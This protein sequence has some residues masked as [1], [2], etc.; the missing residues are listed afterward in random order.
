M[1]HETIHGRLLYTSKKPEIL[2]KVRGGETFT[3]TRHLDG[4]RTL[5]AQCAI[6]ENSPRVLRDSITNLDAAWRPKEAFVQITVDEEF[7][8]SSWYRFTDTTAECEGFTAREGR[9]SQKIE[10]DQPAPFFGTH[11]IQAD[12]WHTHCYDMSKGPGEQTVSGYLMCS[13]HHRG[14]DGPLLFKQDEIVFAFVGR[15]T[16]EVAA[17]RFAALHF[18]I[19]DNTDDDYMKTDRHP[20]YHIWVT[21]DGDYVMLKAYC[22]G[23]MQTYYELVEYERR[24]NFF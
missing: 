11:P 8:G 16:V 20:P 2:D 18:R 19:G 6:D 14:A 5:R 4:R 13:L 21:D 17:G 7:A 15:E 24:T 1:E 10:L 23:Y 22:T 12:A 9:I 3:I